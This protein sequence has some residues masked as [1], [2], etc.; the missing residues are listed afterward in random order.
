MTFKARVRGIYSTAITKILLDNGFEIVQ[1]S[2][3]IRE[4]FK[5]DENMQSPDIDIYDRRSRQGVHVL[6]MADALET[7]K[8]ILQQH[9]ADLILRKQSFPID[10]VYKGIIEIDERAGDFVSVN[11]GSL[12]GKLPKHEADISKKPDVIV[13]VQRE[14]TSKQPLLSTK[15]NIPG[16]Y[17]VLIPEQKIKVSLKIRDFEKRANLIELGKKIATSKWGIIWRT[18]AANQPTETLEKE[19]TCL[20]EMG[21]EILRKAKEENAPVLLWGNQ[22]YMNVEFP[23]LSK[24]SL[25]KIRA[26]ISPTIE[27]HHYYKACGRTV[28]VALQ[29]AEK[30]LEG[31]ASREEIERLFHETVESN[32]PSEGSFID[33]EHVKPDGKVVHL[34][35]ALVERFSDGELCYSRVF[36][37]GGL[38]D[39]LDLPKQPGDRAVTEAKIGGWHYTTRYFSK[40]GEYKGA[41][42]NFH[43]P[44]ELYPRWI[45][46][47]DLEVDI[48][49]LPDG[50]V[51]VVDEDELKKA[52]AE[53]FISE[54]LAGIVKA[55]VL[56]VLKNL[57]VSENHR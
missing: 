32:Y 14:Y 17:A 38:Y 40:N 50:A 36:K 33:I 21:E 29:M 13:Q 11:L 5:L 57:P 43:T 22:Y 34:G 26:P 53:G 24:I 49:A 12:I 4:R 7:L 16:E 10:G 8:A 55:K 56:E 46:Y 52:V 23:A 31:S 28:S 15:I 18:T 48:C 3:A 19:I 20:A 44:L 35:K 51:K 9:L 25:D 2:Q 1:P 47:V 39:S 41:H 42:V 37:N 30:M 27:E 6:G 45:R 54:N